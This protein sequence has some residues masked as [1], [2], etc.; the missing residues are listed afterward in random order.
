MVLV[1]SVG[2]R[3]TNPPSAARVES[4]SPKAHVDAATQLEIDWTSFSSTSLGNPNDGSLRGGVPLPLSARGLR[5]NPSRDPAARFGTVEVVRALVD[6]AEIVDAEFGGIGVTINDLSHESGGPIPRHE[7]HQN[8]RDVDVF[9]YQLGPSGRP[10][11]S[12][13]AFFDPNGLGVDFRDL[14]DPSDDVELRLDIPRTW[15]FVEALIRDERANLQSIYVAEHLRELLLD[16]GRAHCADDSTITR[17]EEMT[18]QPK[19]PHD[20]HFHFRFY[21][22][23]DDIKAGCRDSPPLYPWRKEA[24]AAAGLRS[25]PLLPKSGTASTKTVSHEEARQAAGPLD[26]EVERW[27]DRRKEWRDKPHPGRRYCR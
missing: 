1:V 2:C 18:C 5:F 10:I 8:G 13:G 22:S 23:D 25:L 3:A 11:E 16:Y 12:V 20:D 17:F 15:H 21:C 4:I 6:A 7:S 19:Y 27:L 24:L 14:A 26:S 9:F